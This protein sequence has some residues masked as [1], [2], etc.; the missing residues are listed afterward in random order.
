MSFRSLKL[1]E[2]TQI[3]S[4]FYLERTEKGLIH[5]VKKNGNLKKVG[6][7]LLKENLKEFKTLDW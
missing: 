4:I 6:L 2:V 5:Y 3:T 7:E 1:N